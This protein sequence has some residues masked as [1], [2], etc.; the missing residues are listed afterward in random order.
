MKLKTQW[1]LVLMTATFIINTAAGEIL[2]AA[3]QRQVL[4]H[5][6]ND[7]NQDTNVLTGL[8]DKSATASALEVSVVNSQ[9]QTTRAT[10]FT[11][12]QI[13]SPSGAVLAVEAGRPVVLIQG[14]ID[15]HMGGNAILKYLTNILTGNYAECQTQIRRATNGQWQIVNVYSGTPVS[16]GHIQTWTLGIKAIK[17]VCPENFGFEEIEY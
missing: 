12:A 13:A 17:G 3:P 7:R 14:K 15:P 16:H 5:L 6:T 8:I 11:L 9:G 4:I 10:E 2:Q 1:S